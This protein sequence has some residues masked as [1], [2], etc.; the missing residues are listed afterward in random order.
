MLVWA[1]VNKGTSVP[2]SI[3]VIDEELAAVGDRPPSI[4]S[5]ISDQRLRSGRRSI[6]RAMFMV[7]LF[8]VVVFAV[9][10]LVPGAGHRLAK[11]SPGWLAVALGLELLACLGYVLLF[12]TVFS[13]AS[14]PVPI[15]RAVQIALA[16][17]RAFAITPTGIG[18]P[19]GGTW[20]VRA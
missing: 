19:A 4:G 17:L 7:V 16:Q 6:A 20:G 10:Q 11:A 1:A 3:H 18:G 5:V 15:R 14:W 13:R 8:A 9:D 12:Q 2:D